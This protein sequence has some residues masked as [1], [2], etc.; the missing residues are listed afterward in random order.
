LH[1][2]GKLLT[3]DAIL[4][5]PGALTDEE[6]DIVERHPIDGEALLAP[7]PHLAEAAKIVRCHHERPDGSGYPDRLTAA[8]IPLG[9]SIVSVV[10][11]WD[12]MVNDRPTGTACPPSA[13][14]PSCPAVPS[15]RARDGSRASSATRLPARRLASRAGDAQH[16]APR[17]VPL[18]RPMTGC[19]CPAVARPVRA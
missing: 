17:S 13:P 15:K 18:S 19:R 4:T 5:K 10:D 12:A 11:A 14:R 16:R 2:V 1:D 3:P 7:Y 9:A 8:Q 6:R